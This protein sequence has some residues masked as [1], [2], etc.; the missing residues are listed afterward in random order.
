[1]VVD[2]QMVVKIVIILV[3]AAIAIAKLFG[4]DFGTGIVGI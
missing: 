1:M 2:K 4:F 3:G